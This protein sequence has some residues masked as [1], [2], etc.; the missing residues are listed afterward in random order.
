M[1]EI[2]TVPPGD[3]HP[4]T[5][6]WNVLLAITKTSLSRRMTVEVDAPVMATDL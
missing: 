4:A 2:R 3:L 1:H 6:S 5:A